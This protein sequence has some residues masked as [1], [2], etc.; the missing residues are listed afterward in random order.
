MGRSRAVR[1]RNFTLRTI[2]LYLDV[3]FLCIIL[4]LFT[5]L[6]LCSLCCDLSHCVTNILSIIITLSGLC[7]LHLGLFCLLVLRLVV[8]CRCI[9][10]IVN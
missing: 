4:Y 1:H 6:I 2:F 3:S 10:Q 8:I 7:R 5:E 9:E